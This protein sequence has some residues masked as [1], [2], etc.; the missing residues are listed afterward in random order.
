M[1]A[2]GVCV[3]TNQII[4]DTPAGV[5]LNRIAD[6]YTELSNRTKAAE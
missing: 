6:R 3:A 4:G 1:A 2:M 5:T